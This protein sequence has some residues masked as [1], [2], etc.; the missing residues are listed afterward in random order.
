MVQQRIY[1]YFER[2][3]RLHV[4]FIFD[5]MDLIRTELDEVKEWAAGYIY[6]VFDGAW[7][8]TKHAIENDWKD[9][10]VVL[11]FSAGTYPHTETEQLRFPLLDM[12]KANMEYKEED[13]ASYMQQYNLPEKFRG[14]IKKHIGEMMSS[15][16]SN[17]LNGH[18]DS[19][20][21]SEDLVCRAFISSYLGDRKLL[22]WET[23]IVK[24]LILDTTTEEKKRDDFWY[25]S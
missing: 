19:A 17:I 21:F 5:S 7:F 22:E 1:N 15:R 14:F 12:L 25:T 16:V 6:K 13:Y 23:I 10:H 8:N 11:L 18:I 4:L 9:K 3:P 20:T 24:T 2:N